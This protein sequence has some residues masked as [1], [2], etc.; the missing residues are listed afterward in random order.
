MSKNIIICC[1]G[2]GNRLSLETDTNVI[3]LYACLEIN[4]DQVAYYSPG[5]GNISSQSWS[6][7]KKL[8]ILTDKAEGKSLHENVLDAYEF[9]MNI[10]QRGDNIYLFGFSR[11]AYSVRMLCGMIEM[12]GLLYSGNRNHIKYILDIYSKGD[13]KFEVANKFKSIFAQT[14]E[15][16]FVGV[17]DTVVSMG[18]LLKFYKSYPYS[19]Q[20]NIV[21][22][23]RHAISI[24]ERRKH[25]DYSSVNARKR[26]GLKEVFFAGVH[27]DIGGGYDEEGLSKVTLEWMIGELQT[28]NIKLNNEK[29]YKVLYDD[30]YNPEDKRI[31]INTPIH[32]SLTF[33][34]KLLDFLPRFRFDKSSIINWRADF[35]LWPQRFIPSGSLIHESVLK[36]MKTT[37]YSPKNLPIEYTIE[38]SRPIVLNS[39]Q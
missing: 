20:L 34:N 21:K 2:T 30:K 8:D 28:Q 15:I 1:D 5:V 39:H 13:E 27:S 4:K 9:L 35:R 17:W 7:R 31:N 24:D 25:F 10:Y 29:I 37:G 14:I 12:F 33:F 38:S 19:R 23:V 32:N 22:Q 11:G 26:D 36:K 3:H 18:N 6:W 16:E